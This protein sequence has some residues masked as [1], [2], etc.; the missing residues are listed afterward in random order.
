VEN[1]KCTSEELLVILELLNIKLDCIDFYELYVN[2]IGYTKYIFIIEKINKNTNNVTIYSDDILNIKNLSNNIIIKSNLVVDSWIDNITILNEDNKTKKEVKLERINKKLGLIINFTDSNLDKIEIIYNR[3]Y[4]QETYQDLEKF[5]LLGV[6]D[7]ESYL[8]ENHESIPYAIGFKT[9]NDLKT[10]YITDYNNNSDEMILKCFEDLLTPK[11]HNLKIYAHCMGS[12]DGWLILKTLMRTYDKHNYKFNIFTNNEG[13]L[14]SI[15]IVKK[16]FNK[17]I[18]KITILDSYLILPVKLSNLGKIFKCENQKS[19]FPYNFINVNTLSY[20][21]PVP[22]FSYF[23]CDTHEY[24]LY[25]ASFI[26]NNW[27]SKIETIK[28]LKLDLLSLYEVKIAF[29]DVMYTKF[30]VNISRIKTTSGLAFLIYTS[31]F[32]KSKETPIYFSD[33]K[34]EKYIRSSYMG[35]IVDVNTH[36]IDYDA[37]KYDINSHYSNAMLKPMPGGLPRF[38]TEKNLDNIFGFVEAIVIAPSESVLLNATL[39]TKINGCTELF[40]GTAHGVWFSEELKDARNNGYVIKEIIS[41]VIYDKVYNFFD[42]YIKSIYGLKSEAEINRQDDLRFIYKLLLN[43]LYGR[44]GLRENNFM[45]SLVP[46][47]NLEQILLTENSDILYKANNLNLIR[48]SGPLDPEILRIIKQEK[49]YS[50]KEEGMYKKAWGSTNSSV[51]FSAAIT[52]YARI[53]L[54]Q[55]KNMKDI[56]YLGEDTDSAIFNKRLPDCYVGKELG[57]FKLEFIIIEGLFHSKK[58]YCLKTKDGHIIIKA[59]GINNSKSILNYDMFCEL[60]KGKKYW[61]KTNTIYK[62]FK[63]FKC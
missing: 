15:D 50:N 51:Q 29:N 14:I 58:F 38:S 13:D 28:Y 5:S 37:Y 30:G 20:Q 61:I 49:M 57:L 2:K 44:F 62:R 41:C 36:Y 59:K 27:D 31:N 19:I 32:Y 12:F 24:S 25:K 52:A 18:I 42:S 11:N 47:E 45:L 8:N 53:H 3:K 63:K 26:K 40:R 10:Y 17:K 21:G 39:P 35:G 34:L 4:L 23:E 55:F 46:E 56:K 1:I 54:N 9:N 60:F 16:L 7:I 33:G 48:S 43:S 6:I 22:H